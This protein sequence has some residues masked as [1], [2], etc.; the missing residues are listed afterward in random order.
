MNLP[1]P[2][3]ALIFWYFFYLTKSA[4]LPDILTQ[5][6]GKHIGILYK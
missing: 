2:T 4:F 3:E 5:I 1:V 6:E